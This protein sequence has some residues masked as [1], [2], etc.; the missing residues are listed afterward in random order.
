MIYILLTVQFVISVPLLHFLWNIGSLFVAFYA[1]TAMTNYGAA[2]A[3]ALMI[4][5][6]VTI[7]DRQA[8]GEANVEATL[9]LFLVTLIAV[10]MAPWG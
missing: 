8:S 1:V 3:F 2:I 5:V 4:S 6:G 9:Y 10:A 7:W